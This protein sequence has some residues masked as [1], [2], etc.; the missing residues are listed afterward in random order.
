MRDGVPTR[1]SSRLGNAAQVSALE[2]GH[3]TARD[4]TQGKGT[5]RLPDVD[6]ATSHT[7][8]NTCIYLYSPTHVSVAPFK[9]HIKNILIVAKNDILH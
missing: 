3:S 2:D 6:T 5:L 7:P 4:S 1:K 9:I 8:S